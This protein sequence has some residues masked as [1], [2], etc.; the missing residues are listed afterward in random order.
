M[1]R[2]SGR[3]LRLQFADQVVRVGGAGKSAPDEI[4]VREGRVALV[5]EKAEEFRRRFP[6]VPILFRYGPFSLVPSD[7]FP[8]SPARAV[9]FHV[10]HITG[11]EVIVAATSPSP[12][13]P[14]ATIQQLVEAIDRDPYLETLRE[15]T[16]HSRVSDKPGF[17]KAMDFVEAR[18]GELGW[19]VAPR[20]ELQFNYDGR[21]WTS[22]NLIARSKIGGDSEGVYVACAHLDAIC[23]CAGA[24]WGAD[25]NASGCAALLEI[26]R[27]FAATSLKHELRLIFF[28]GEEQHLRGSRLYVRENPVGGTHRAVVNLDMIGH[29]Y[30]GRI[31]VRL[32]RDGQRAKCLSTEL[33]RSAA[34]YVPALSVEETDEDIESDHTSF[35]EEAIKAVMACELG[36]GNCHPDDGCD[37][38]IHTRDDTVDRIDPAQA[39]AVTR[40]VAAYLAERLL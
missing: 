2:A 8:E 5:V 33:A 30:G 35:S 31:G 13:I 16:K 19:P 34:T 17:V 27:I 36:V 9:G 40:M 25:D 24:A 12:C 18:L 20:M 23:G 7:R 22:Y 21:K 29:L 38:V 28:G 26:A 39:I 10:R 32:V 37:S 11:D 14:T 6:G 15:I 3:G 1:N 4:H